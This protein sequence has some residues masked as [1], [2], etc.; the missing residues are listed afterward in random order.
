MTRRKINSV[1]SFYFTFKLVEDV[2]IVLRVIIIAYYKIFFIKI[3][4]F[5]NN[6][7]LKKKEK[8]YKWRNGHKVSLNI[9]N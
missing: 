2:Y 6:L 1:I 7:N 3:E 5:Q 9:W 8:C 4:T